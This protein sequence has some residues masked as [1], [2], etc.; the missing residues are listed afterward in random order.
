MLKLLEVA[1]ACENADYKVTESFDVVS[2]HVYID[3]G[4]HLA[5]LYIVHAAYIVF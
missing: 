1:R 2:F 4:Q 5:Q 3:S